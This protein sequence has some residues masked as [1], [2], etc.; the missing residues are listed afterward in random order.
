MSAKQEELLR[1]QQELQQL[2]AAHN[3]ATIEAKEVRNLWEAEVRI[4]GC[5]FR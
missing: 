2:K 3:K 4:S 1:M 5:G